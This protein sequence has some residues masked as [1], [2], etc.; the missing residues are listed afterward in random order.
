ML[1][2]ENGEEEIRPGKTGELWIR[3]PNTMKGYW[4]NAKATAETLT[5]DGW[6]KTGD[7][8]YRDEAGK[9]YMVDRK[10]VNFIFLFLCRS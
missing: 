2:K 3:T 1:V 10:K 9:W 5:D 7:I 6:L 4:K 8:A